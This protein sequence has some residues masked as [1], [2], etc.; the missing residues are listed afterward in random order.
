MAAEPLVIANATLRVSEQQIPPV[1]PL[2]KT[3][4]WD[5][6]WI[7]PALHD[8]AFGPIGDATPNTFF[9]VD[10][11][12]RREV[13]GVF[14]LDVVDVPIA[15]LYEADAAQD[16]AETAPYL[17][18]LTLNRAAP[19]AFHRDLFTTHWQAGTGIL[20]RSTADMA[21]LRR[22]LRRFTMTENASGRRMFFRFWEPNILRDYYEHLAHHRPQRVQDIFRLRSGDRIDRMIGHARGTTITV[23]A[24]PDRIPEPGP[25]KEPF[26]LS[27][28]EEDALYRSVLRRHAKDIADQINDPDPDRARSQRD[29]LVFDCILR[30][31][32]HDIRQL[33]NLKSLAELDLRYGGAFEDHLPGMKAILSGPGSEDARMKELAASMGVV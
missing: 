15:C 26:R 24:A 32:R 2:A 31:R 6:P 11:I 10:A 30:M 25:A 21:T 23:D 9:V 5:Q 13:V 19:G 17:V 12:L 22:H 29:A 7:T 18:D 16:Y 4:F 20:I 33:K 14:D 3:P 8:L 1:V 28:G 27:P